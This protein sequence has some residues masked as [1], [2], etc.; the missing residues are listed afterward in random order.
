M[1]VPWLSYGMLGKEESMGK[2]IS[3]EFK[4]FM[5]WCRMARCYDCKE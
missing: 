3:S 2:E 5:K 1:E 4:R